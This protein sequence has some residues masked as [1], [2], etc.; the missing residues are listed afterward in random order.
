MKNL[1]LFLFL[2]VVFPAIAKA[3]SVDLRYC[4]TCSHA[5]WLITET[6]ELKISPTT[7]DSVARS[8]SVLVEGSEKVLTRL[9]DYDRSLTKKQVIAAAL[10]G[11]EEIDASRY[12]LPDGLMPKSLEKRTVAQRKGGH[13]SIETESRSVFPL[14]ILFLFLSATLLGLAWVL[15]Q[16]DDESLVK[17]PGG[18]MLAMAATSACL[19]ASALYGLMLRSPNEPVV[20]LMIPFGFMGGAMCLLAYG[21]ILIL[22]MLAAGGLSKLF[23]KKD[24]FDDLWMKI[25]SYIALISV[26]L[27]MSSL[28]PLSSSLKNF[29]SA[30]F[31]VFLPGI[32][33]AILTKTLA[34]NFL[35][36]KETT[37]I[38]DR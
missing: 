37:A 34:D 16:E 33:V 9:S 21:L 7:T 29:P 22:S 15:M 13:V 5:P 8:G 35:R 4:A 10:K 31:L 24:A 2:F 6:G 36:A 12:Y 28:L 14:E 20:L 30:M 19:C 1:R 18:W 27:L 38:V 3:N 23:F 11:K 25:S 17:C 32:S 26:L